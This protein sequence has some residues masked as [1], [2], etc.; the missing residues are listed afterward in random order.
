MNLLHHDF[1]FPSSAEE[2]CYGKI[3]LKGKLLPR[4]KRMRR[5]SKPSQSTFESS[6][7]QGKSSISTSTSTFFFSPRLPSP[8][9][10]GNSSFDTSDSEKIPII[11]SI[12]TFD[13]DAGQVLLFGEVVT[14][15]WFVSCAL[16]TLYF[17]ASVIFFVV[18]SVLY[19]SHFPPHHGIFN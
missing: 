16:D 12:G 2:D 9:N 6:R 10:K 4:C 19:H 8:S 17:A 7:F 18:D 11:G 14:L 5:K 1:S 3:L 15:F 13:I